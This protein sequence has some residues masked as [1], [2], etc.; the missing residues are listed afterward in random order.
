LKPREGHRRRN[1]QSAR[2]RRCGTARGEFCF[3]GF[4]DRPF[5]AFVEVS[6]RLGW[7]Q[8]VR[9]PQ[10]QPH[11]EPIF[12]LRNRLGDRRLADPKLLR[13]PGKRAGLD[14]AGSEWAAVDTRP[15]APLPGGFC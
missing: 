12:E 14:Y 7:R 4:F 15:A 3:L 6:T 9:R 11:T 8:G 1:P 5:G 10:Q 13:S 2:E